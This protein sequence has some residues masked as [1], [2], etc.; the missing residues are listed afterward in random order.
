MA[1]KPVALTATSSN[2]G[3]VNAAPRAQARKGSEAFGEVYEE[4]LNGVYRYLYARTTNTEDASDLTQQ[5]FLKA[6][7]GFPT[8]RDQGH[9]ISA[10]LFKIAHNTVV[11]FHRR[12][13]PTSS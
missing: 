1:T 10:W 11:D 7:E 2:R 8:Y 5:V 12:R 9:P 13:R 6:F 3:G 4:Y